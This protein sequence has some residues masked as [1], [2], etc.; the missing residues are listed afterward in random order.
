MEQQLVNG[1]EQDCL[2]LTYLDVNGSKQVVNI[3]LGDFLRESEFKNGLQVNNGEVSVKLGEGNESFLTVGADGVKLSGV[4][5][6][7]NAAKSSILGNLD[8]T[9]AKTL[10]SINDELNGLDGKVVALEK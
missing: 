6:A 5:D 4:Q 7:I 9:D 1:L 2:I 8:E 3:P 10:E